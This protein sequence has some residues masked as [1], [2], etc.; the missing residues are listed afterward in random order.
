ARQDDLHEHILVE[1]EA[2]ALRRTQQA[3]LPIA[4]TGEVL[5]SARV[6][7]SL[8]IGNRP[9][10]FGM[11]PGAIESNGRAPVVQDKRHVRGELQCLEPRIH[12]TRLIHEAIGFGWRLA[13]PTHPHEVWRETAANGTNV[14][15]DI[16]PLVRPSGI[17]VEKDNWLTLPH[18][19]IADFG[20][21]HFHSAPRQAVWTFRF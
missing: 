16:A 9:D 20:I 19:D 12:V 10:L 8:V 7:D 14:R 3:E 11:A 21:E 1:H 4:A 6:S 17:A 13:G 2:L 18:V 15:N 5:P